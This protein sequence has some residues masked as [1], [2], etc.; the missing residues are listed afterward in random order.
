MKILVKIS[1]ILEHG[2]IKVLVSFSLALLLIMST[3]T[4]CG[5][6]DTNMVNESNSNRQENYEHKDK[7]ADYSEIGWN[8]QNDGL[9][10]NEKKK[11]EF[12]G[13]YPDGEPSFSENTC[14]GLV[15]SY[16]RESDDAAVIA[17]NYSED[18]GENWN[19]FEIKGDIS[20][21][22]E[23]FTAIPDNNVIY[24]LYC[25][26]AALGQMK[27]VLYVCDNERALKEHDLTD[28]TSNYPLGMGFASKNDGII[29]LQNHGDQCYMLKTSD[30]GKS[31]RKVN[32]YAKDT[33][34]A[35]I[36]AKKIER[37]GNTWYL[38]LNAVGDNSNKEIILI[39]EDGFKTWIQQKLRISAA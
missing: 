22:G 27:K 7:R 34:Y 38:T 26:D 19:Y 8:I 23:V 35:Y 17:V 9:Y 32:D 24:V 36:D 15:C 4:S 20:G 6:T 28:V 29:I 3:C 25:S 37:Y 18:D 11:L 21:G 1:G 33:D 12:K 31:F 10:Y 14:S 16:I 39:S 13:K 5:V 30:G 2:E